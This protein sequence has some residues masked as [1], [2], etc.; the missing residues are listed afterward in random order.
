MS[1]KLIH[2]L[3]NI[4]LASCSKEEASSCAR[5]LRV[6]ALRCLET[7]IGTFNRKV[8]IPG[9]TREQEKMRYFFITQGNSANDLTMINI[10]EIGSLMAIVLVSNKAHESEVRKMA[11]KNFLVGVSQDDWEKQL[12]VLKMLKQSLLNDPNTLTNSSAEGILA[13]P[14]Q[15]TSVIVSTLREH[16][17]NARHTDAS[18]SASLTLKDQHATDPTTDGKMPDSGIAQPL[19]VKEVA[20]S[21]THEAGL[22]SSIE[23]SK[24]CDHVNPQ[25]VDQSIDP[26][27]EQDKP[28]SLSK[29]AYEAAIEN[30]VNLAVPSQDKQC[31]FYQDLLAQDSKAVAQVASFPE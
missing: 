15:L 22:R 9:E 28:S 5:Q 23:E 11:E 1:N 7:L 18:C 29:P 21:Q 20:T 8:Y 3:S 13:P 14:S 2:A 16:E 25:D 26:A 30:S 31:I 10:G 12:W 24:D 27:N 6:A 4:A 19:A 17:S